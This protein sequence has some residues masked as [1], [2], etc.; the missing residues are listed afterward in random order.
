MQTEVQVKM[1]QQNV[2]MKVERVLN[3]AS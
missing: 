1:K 2:E 3:T